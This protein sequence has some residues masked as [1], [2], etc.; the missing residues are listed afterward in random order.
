MKYILI[1]FFS[2][3]SISLYSQQDSTT[4]IDKIYLEDGTTLKGKVVTIKKDV[5]D[6]IDSETNLSYEFAKSEIKFIQLHNGKTLTFKDKPETSEP[7]SK[8]TEMKGK[9]GQVPD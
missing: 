4:K 3:R 7:K 1:I 6:F 8:N 2:L 9:E 5:V